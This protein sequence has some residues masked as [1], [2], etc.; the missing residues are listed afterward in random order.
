[1][2]GQRTP[3]VSVVVLSWN[4]RDLLRSCLLSLEADPSRSEHELIVVDNGSED[5]SPALVE[6]EFPDVLLIQNGRNLGYA[7]GNNVGIRAAGGRHVL[8]LNS[9]TEVEP[10][11]ISLLA[12]FLDRHPEAG[13]VGARLLLP[14]GSVQRACMRFPTL[15]V[16]I[17][18]D[19][20]FG[21]R[22][23]LKRAID[24]YF[25]REF[26]HL[27]SRDVDQPPGAALMVPR[28][29]YE[30][31]GLLDPDLFLF[32]ND[33]DLCR[34]IRA[35]GYRIH[36]LAESRIL[37]HGGASTSRYGDF[38]Q[39]W[40]LNRARYYLRSHGRAGFWLAKLMSAWRALEEWW[41]QIRRIDDAEARRFATERL[42][43]IVRLVFLDP[44]RG[45]ARV[46]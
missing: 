34:R 25:Y 39:E 23:P 30:T 14:D 38:A 6:R 2:T 46:R 12:D 43:R 5:G 33:V 22:F 28:R 8:L 29:L 3:R 42:R 27:S 17:G 21:R 16:V 45:D 41:R 13:A 19:T 7:A 18:F 31:L 40:H 36:Y 26:D 32:F 4:T 10:G 44:G 9:D 15:A 1:M 35:A 37:H 20:W 24:R 11:A